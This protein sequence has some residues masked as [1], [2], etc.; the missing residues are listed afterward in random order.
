MS[1][2]SYTSFCIT[3][4]IC[5]SVFAEYELFSVLVIDVLSTLCV[6]HTVDT[7]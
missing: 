4:I 6:W 5:F 1:L 7:I 3:V 2:R